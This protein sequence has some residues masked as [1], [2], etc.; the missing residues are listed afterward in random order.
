MPPAAYERLR[1]AAA[2][3]AGDPA[4]APFVAS[5]TELVQAQA[6][7]TGF[8]VLH[9][10]AEI[11]DWHFPPQQPDGTGRLTLVL[12]CGQ[13]RGGSVGHRAQPGRVSGG[14]L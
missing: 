11:L 13:W 2:S 7:R 5:P 3:F 10:W 8:V 14:R 1:A 4:A 9:E 6:E 12:P